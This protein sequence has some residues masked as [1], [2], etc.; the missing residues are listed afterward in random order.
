MNYA[1]VAV[2]LKLLQLVELYSER[3]ASVGTNVFLGA[4][5]VE[6]LTSMS[7]VEGRKIAAGYREVL[8]HLDE[9]P[10]M[11]TNRMLS[12]NHCLFLRNLIRCLALPCLLSGTESTL[13]DVY[14]T[15]KG[16]RGEV[17]S[18]PWAWLLTKFPLNNH[19]Y[20]TTHLSTFENHMLT[21]SRPLFIKW[22]IECNPSM[23]AAVAGS[24]AVKGGEI[25]SACCMTPHTLSAMK[26]IICWAKLITKPRACF[27][28]DYHWLHASLMLVFA[29]SLQK[30]SSEVDAL[31]TDDSLGESPT[32][33][34]KRPNVA[35]SGSKK[36]RKL[37]TDIRNN[38]MYHSLVIRNHFALLHVANCTDD[39]GMMLLHLTNQSNVTYASRE[40]FE[41]RAAFKTCKEDPLLY[42]VNFRDG[43]MLRCAKGEKLLQVPSTFAFSTFQVQSR[44]GNTKAPSN[45]GIGLEV[46][47]MAAIVL[48]SHRYTS[49]EGTAFFRWLALVVAELSEQSAFEEIPICDIPAE[50][51][52]ALGNVH[53]PILSAPNCPWSEES[54]KSGINFGNFT[55]CKN[56]EEKDGGVVYLQKDADHNDAFELTTTKKMNKKNAEQFK[57]ELVGCGMFFGSGYITISTEIKDRSSFGGKD[58]KSVIEKVPSNGICILIG[59]DLSNLRKS[60][61]N[62]FAT[63]VSVYT[64]IKKNSIQR[65]TA[66]V[67]RDKWESG[68]RILITLD[69][70]SIYPNRRAA[71]P[72]AT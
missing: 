57:K 2:L 44:V 39:C 69:L 62:T 67:T 15:S 52:G 59:A 68:R 61:V 47:S 4:N 6:D 22:F 45:D 30:G 8:V 5:V 56:Y 17:D 71:V 19:G 51:S 36:T 50:L 48:A 46:E 64:M 12:H 63:D 14:S 65:V 26:Q 40:P 10:E 23:T 24:V 66:E 20:S 53:V 27:D 49:F 43:L 13:L 11:D 35:A 55:W 25:R 16:S 31:V 37:V 1:T 33:N 60:T 58:M 34:R 70:K 32:S 7:L 9:I 54:M 41:V 18:R 42:L 38:T 21:N 28:V 3:D 72:H 29:D